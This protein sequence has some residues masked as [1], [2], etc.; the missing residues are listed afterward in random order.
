MNVAKALK[1]LNASNWNLGQVGTLY[2]PGMFNSKVVQKGKQL[3][4]GQRVDKAVI[5]TQT[6][7][8]C[9]EI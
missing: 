1:I 4:Q 3:T 5:A 6:M 7:D 8:G 9:F 2:K